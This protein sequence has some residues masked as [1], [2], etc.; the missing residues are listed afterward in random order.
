MDMGPCAM[1]P[2]DLVFVDSDI[3]MSHSPTFGCTVPDRVIS[4]NYPCLVI[5]VQDPIETKRVHLGGQFEILS[6]AYVLTPV[7]VGWV[8]QWNLRRPDDR[9]TES[10][11]R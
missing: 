5:A 7:G 1:M 11:S 6:W 8:K 3:Y 2:G 10:V 9:N 4:S